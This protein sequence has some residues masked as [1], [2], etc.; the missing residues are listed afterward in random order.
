MHP[1][2]I[3]GPTCES[4]RSS[5]LSSTGPFAHRRRARGKYDACHICFPVEIAFVG[6]PNVP[7]RQRPSLF[8]DRHRGDWRSSVWVLV[9]DPSV[10]KTARGSFRPAGCKMARRREHEKK[11]GSD[12][13]LSHPLQVINRRSFLQ[14]AGH[15]RGE[16]S[17]RIQG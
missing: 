1:T 3:S 5:F 10:S 12:P 6:A 17:Q 11:L 8:I 2:L 7:T 9:A 4:F 13:K 14:E 15:F 16:P